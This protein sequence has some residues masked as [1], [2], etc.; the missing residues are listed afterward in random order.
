[1]TPRDLA[2][3]FAQTAL[4]LLPWPTEAGL[5]PVGNP[6]P[7]SP[8]VVTGNY[9]LTVRRVLR[10]LRGQNLWL[11]VAPSG[12]INVW[13]AAAGGMLTT[14]Q[15]VTALKTSGVEDC[16]RHRRAFLPQLAATGVSSRELSK[17]C[18]WKAKFGPVR[19]EDLA[20]YLSAHEKKTDEMR[21]VR[22]G[23]QERLEAAAMWGMPAAAVLGLG[24]AA[25]RP[26]WA[27][28]LMALALA[29]AAAVF[30]VYEH[31]PGPR[32]LLFTLGAIGVA[33]G[34]VATAGGGMPALAT[35]AIA[36]AGL[37][38]LLTFDYPGSTPIEGGAHF[39]SVRWHI[40]LDR[41]RCAG[42]YSCVEV[43]PEACFEPQPDERKVD[44]A[45]D[46][47]C[48]KCGACVVQCPQD[49][50]SFTD[51]TGVRIPPDQIRRYKLNLLGQRS[52][53]T[54]SNSIAEAG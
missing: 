7:E 39:D 11:V 49:A 37:I 13:C 40:T 10:A 9:A 21:R 36:G 47:R 24:A 30:L 19:I 34:S 41:E 32:R 45:Y 29:L 6:G 38:G 48:V 35:A 50:L 52:I 51:S 5:R 46:E 17:R 12:G 8:V 20:A 22:F 54:G 31:T 28:P 44:L 27:L 42:V 4:R 33:V 18:G 15:V 53:D 23:T 43:C 2:L 14:H 16:V 3:D 1:V 25:I 26:T